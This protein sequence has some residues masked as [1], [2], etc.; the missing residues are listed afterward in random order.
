M[1]G[2][3]WLPG[4]IKHRLLFLCVVLL[5]RCQKRVKD[6]LTPW[7]F[8]P[9][10]EGPAGMSFLTLQRACPATET[11]QRPRVLLTSHGEITAAPLR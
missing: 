3:R 8:F 2:W 10:G 11:S 9:E 5:L 1:S 7:R 6:M 4:R